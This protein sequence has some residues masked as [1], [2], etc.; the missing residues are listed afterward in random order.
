MENKCAQ[1]FENFIPNP[2]YHPLYRKK[3]L[4]QFHLRIGCASESKVVLK[5][6][7]FVVRYYPSMIIVS[8]NQQD[9]TYA[10]LQEYYIDTGEFENP[11]IYKNGTLNHTKRYLIILMIDSEYLF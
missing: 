1:K 6:R 7:D 9:Y 8:N 3:E 5:L 4:S 10:A 2:G 11:V